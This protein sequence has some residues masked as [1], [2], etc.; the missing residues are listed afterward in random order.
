M[1]ES[2]GK[3]SGDAGVTAFSL[4]RES[5]RVQFRDRSVYI[6][7]YAATGKGKVEQMKKLAK[8]GKGLTTFINRHVKNHYAAKIR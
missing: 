4:G 6:Y 5:I 1:M 8:S 3:K 7:S 2:Y